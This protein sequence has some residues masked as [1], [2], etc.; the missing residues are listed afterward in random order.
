MLGGSGLNRSAGNGSLRLLV[1]PTTGP[2]RPHSDS[3]VVEACRANTL[4]D[5]HR[6]DPEFGHRLLE[7]EGRD[8]G[9]AMPDQTGWRIKIGSH[10][11]DSRMKSSPAVNA[12]ENA[13]T[14]RGDVAGC[15]V[16]SD[17]GSPAVFN[18]SKPEGPARSHPPPDGRLDGQGHLLRCQRSDGIV[19]QRAAEERPRPPLLGHQ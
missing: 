2:G 15:V 9:R 5:A 19:V 4:F 18:R 16:H 17:R 14:M 12:L 13:V 10:S 6:D 7:G 3:E 11:L 8:A 1:S